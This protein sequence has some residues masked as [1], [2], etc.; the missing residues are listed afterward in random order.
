MH[1]SLRSK[2]FFAVQEQRMRNKSQSPREKWLSF[3]F[4]RGQNR[5]S[6]SSVSFCSETKRKRSLRRLDAFLQDNLINLDFW[7][8]ARRPL[9]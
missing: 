7:E 4:S 9:P 2:R 3:H 6:P 8:T 1:S 5:K